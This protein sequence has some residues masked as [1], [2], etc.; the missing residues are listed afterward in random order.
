MINRQT[1][2]HYEIPSYGVTGPFKTSQKN[3]LKARLLSPSRMKKY[4]YFLFHFIVNDCK[5]Y[6]G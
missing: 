1:S 5:K 2:E 4:K 3:P 6:E